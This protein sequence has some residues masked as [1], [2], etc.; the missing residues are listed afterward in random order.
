MQ[1][2]CSFE[3]PQCRTALL[4]TRSFSDVCSTFHQMRVKLISDSRYIDTY[5]KRMHLKL[6]TKLKRLQP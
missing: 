4:D 5:L 1:S 6:E 2:S 3:P